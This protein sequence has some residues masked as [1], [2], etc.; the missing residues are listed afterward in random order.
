MNNVFNDYYF[1]NW[2]YDI[3]YDFD[4]NNIKENHLNNDININLN[5]FE[6]SMGNIINC[7]KKNNILVGLNNLGSTCFMN[8]VIQALNNINEFSDEI[9]S[10]NIERNNSPIT[11]ALKEVFYNLRKPE[12][13]YHSYSPIQ[14]YNT[15]CKY[16]PKFNEK[17]PNDSRQLLQYILDSIHN[18]LNI[19]KN[20]KYMKEDISTNWNEKLE[21]EINSFN[22]ENQS[23]ISD[24][25]Y[26]ILANETICK[27]CNKI[28][29]EFQHFNI[30][31]LPII[32]KDNSQINIKDMIDDYTRE[33]NLTKKSN[34][35]LICRD[36]SEAKSTNVFYKLPI[37]LIIYPGRKNY[38]VKY[39]ININFE[40]E[41]NIRVNNKLENKIISYNLIA[42][43]YHLGSCGEKGHNIA[44]CKK[45]DVWYM[46]NDSEISIINISKIS[47]EGILLLIYQQK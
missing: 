4:T 39:N 33:H 16:N 45:N 2:Y 40:K 25:F 17:K 31:T 7:F 19:N 32:T 23:I 15:I 43:I 24:L 13:N 3:E 18:E 37:I 30:L 11:K 22:Y 5:N 34:Y 12:N 9:Y 6:N 26:G 21:Y 29:Y 47:G 42:I 14:F 28:S 1:Y 46:F 10:L 27:N 20:N 8:S 41:L 36:Y 38:G 35:C 44:L